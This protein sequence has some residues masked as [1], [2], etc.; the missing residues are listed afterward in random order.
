MFKIYGIW[1][2]VMRMGQ[3]PGDE[4]K[5][6]TEWWSAHQGEIEFTL[7]VLSGLGLAFWRRTPDEDG[8]LDVRSS[9]LLKRLHRDDKTH[10]R[11]LRAR[12]KR[13]RANLARRTLSR[14]K[15]THVE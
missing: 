6:D 11:Y 14:R 4:A 3:H 15:L 9:R 13:L 5:T 7:K 10:C 2:D 1:I 12:D 8:E